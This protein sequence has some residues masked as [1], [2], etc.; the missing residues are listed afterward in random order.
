MFEVSSEFWKIGAMI[1]GGLTFIVGVLFLFTLVKNRD[2][3]DAMS[4]REYFNCK[5]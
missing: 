3:E 2:R 5:D 4:I 1:I